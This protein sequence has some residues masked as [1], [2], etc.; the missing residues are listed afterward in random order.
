MVSAGF[1]ETSDAPLVVLFVSRTVLVASIAISEGEGETLL[2]V[3]A[4]PVSFE[5]FPCRKCNDT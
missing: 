4:N 3:V 1:L 5:R 2:H